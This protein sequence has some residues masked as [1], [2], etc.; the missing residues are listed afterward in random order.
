STEKTENIKYYGRVNY[1]EALKMYSTCDIMFAIYDPTVPNHRY[2]A[3]NKVYEA[4][5]LG[6]PIIVSKGTGVDKIVEK[7]KIGICIDYTEK[8]LQNALD[9]LTENPKVIKEMGN[10]AKK[11]FESYSWDRMRDRLINLYEEIERS[12]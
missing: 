4:M 9:Y 7:E 1:S 8:D 6:K 11:V 12:I 2:S 3:P 10:R 5:M